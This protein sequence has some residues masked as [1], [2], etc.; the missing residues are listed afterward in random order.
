M[1]SALRQPATKQL[2]RPETI[3]AILRCPI[4]GESLENMNSIEVRELNSRAVRGELF[5]NDGTSVRAPIESAYGTADRKYAYAVR[6]D[7]TMMLPSLAIVLRADAASSG[8][9]RPEKKNVQDFYERIG[10]S[11]DEGQEFTDARKYE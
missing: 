10:W 7:I 1:M 11:R 9:L 2:R 5:H 6:E 8:E 4:T 3:E